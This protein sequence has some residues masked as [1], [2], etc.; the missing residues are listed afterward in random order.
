MRTV[1]LISG[2]LFT[3]LPCFYSTALDENDIPYAALHGANSAN[4]S[5]FKRNLQKFKNKEDVKV[6]FFWVNYV[7][8]EKTHLLIKKKPNILGIYL[9]DSLGGRGGDY[10]YLLLYIFTT[11]VH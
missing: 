2:L 6:K 5:K 10:Y 8:N 11:K 4:L 3:V 1:R 9:L 7:G